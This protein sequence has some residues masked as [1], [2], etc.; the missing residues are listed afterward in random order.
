MCVF[1]LPPTLLQT[2]AHTERHT[3]LLLVA[4]F[5]S[6][7]YSAVELLGLLIFAVFLCV[8]VCACPQPARL[9]SI[10]SPLSQFRNDPLL[11]PPA[12]IDLCERWMQSE[13]RR[14]CR[15]EY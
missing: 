15:A 6:D 1:Q 7:R 12:L 5:L 3:R 13:I 11:S 14:C 9:L 2:H 4:G 8:C 10:S